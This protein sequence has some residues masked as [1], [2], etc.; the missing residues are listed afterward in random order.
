VGANRKSRQ[1]KRTAARAEERQEAA[2]QRL[3]AEMAAESR[4]E[5]RRLHLVVLNDQGEVP[6]KA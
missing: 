6:P 3:W 1:Y 2:L 4:R 5:R